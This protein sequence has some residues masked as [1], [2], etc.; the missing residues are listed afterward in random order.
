M[1]IIITALQYC[2]SITAR[3]LVIA[4]CST[5]I[6]LISAKGGALALKSL[7]KQVNIV[8]IAFTLTGLTV[9]NHSTEPDTD[10]FCLT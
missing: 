1:I 9:L 5:F 7:I 10:C 4:N 6:S 2:E 3:F 8:F